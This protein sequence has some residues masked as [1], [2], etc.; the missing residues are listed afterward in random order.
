M[1]ANAGAAQDD[2]SESDRHSATTRECRRGAEHRG[3]D[4]EEDGELDE[5]DAGTVEWHCERAA[6][7]AE[8]EVYVLGGVDREGA[9]VEGVDFDDIEF[10]NSS[11]R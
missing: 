8:G 3:Q 9:S 2:S 6:A 10:S 5:L 7:R 11:Y 4:P 1:L